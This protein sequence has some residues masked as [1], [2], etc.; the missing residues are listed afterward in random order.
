MADW[1]RLDQER[2]EQLK[3]EFRQRQNGQ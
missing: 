1:R 3:R 2:R